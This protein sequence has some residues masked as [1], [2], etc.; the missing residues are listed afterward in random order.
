M[1]DRRLAV[2]AYLLCC[3]LVAFSLVDSAG[4]VWPVHPTEVE[5]RFNANALF[6]RS[7]I[8]LFIGVFL[9]FGVSVVFD[10]KR[11]L[12]AIAYLSAAVAGMFIVATLLFVM[13]A[14]EVIREVSGFRIPAF[15][16][17]AVATMLRYLMGTLVAL[18]IAYCAR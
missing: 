14:T 10:L 2:P 16:G 6:S 9:A 1:R 15:R 17:I 13:D 12:R 8:D 4:A 18:S 11:A 3:C 5:W 7:L